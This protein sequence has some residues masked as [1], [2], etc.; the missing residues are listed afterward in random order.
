MSYFAGLVGA[1]LQQVCIDCTVGQVS[2][3][4]LLYL[5]CMSPQHFT[6][7]LNCYEEDSFGD[8]FLELCSLLFSHSTHIFKLIINIK[9]IN[10]PKSLSAIDF[11]VNLKFFS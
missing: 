7:Y 8:T 11:V 3:K 1:V 9:N 4:Y 5:P 6:E 10:H 2:P